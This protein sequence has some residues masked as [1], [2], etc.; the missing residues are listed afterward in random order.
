MDTR[1]SIPLFHLPTTVVGDDPTG[2][3]RID[4]LA[5]RN[6]LRG[7]RLGLPSGQD[8]AR[9]MGVPPIDDATLGLDDPRWGGQAPLWFYVLKEAELQH[10]GSR[11]GDVGGRIVAETILGILAADRSSYLN[12]APTWRPT[13]PDLRMG[14]LLLLS[15]AVAPPE[16]NP[17]DP[18][19][20]PGAA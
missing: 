4:S 12:A 7:K 20:G 3:P 1:L 11:L 9:A 2:A 17:T 19:A 15:G 13:P 18:G 10:G 5:Q 16:Q 6:L 14:D 8:V